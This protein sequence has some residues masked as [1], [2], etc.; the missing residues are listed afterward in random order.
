M[1]V[2]CMFFAV[3]LGRSLWLEYAWQLLHFIANQAILPLSLYIGFAVL[4]TVFPFLFH[5][6]FAAKTMPWAT[7]ALAAPLH[8]FL[9]YDVIRTAYP[10]GILGLVPA[11]FA[12]PS[13]LGLMV[14]LK[15][16]PPE[17]PTVNAQLALFG[18]AALFFITVIF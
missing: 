5:R 12:V 1:F 13:L 3:G 14:L 8:F 17:S 15:R 11:V 18:G 4:F 9:V 16:T 7:A 10:N 6:Q 2:I